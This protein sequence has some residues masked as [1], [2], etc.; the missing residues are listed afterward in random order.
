MAFALTEKQR[1]RV[2]HRI[3]MGMIMTLHRQGVISQQVF[4]DASRIQREKDQIYFEPDDG[5]AV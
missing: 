2:E 5:E 4:M 1:G 3:K